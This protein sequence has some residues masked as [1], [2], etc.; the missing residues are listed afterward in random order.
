MIVEDAS[1]FARDLMV[2]ELGIL[3]LIRRGV[4]VF[5]SNGED[6]T[7]TNDP[8]KKAMRQI[9]GVF[10]ELEKTRLVSKLKAARDRERAKGK[11]VEGRKALAETQPEAV[12]LARKLRRA[13]PSTGAR[14]SFRDIARR[15]ADGGY[16]A[17]SGKPF[18][19]SVIKRMIEV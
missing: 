4:T 9:A 12:A 14:L 15:F 19:P 16:T 11:K 17:K 3:S 6:L 18:S 5:A 13:K 1:R 2:Q 10:A 8:M 7:Q